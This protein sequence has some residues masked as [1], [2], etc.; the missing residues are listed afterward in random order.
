MLWCLYVV[1]PYVGG[2]GQKNSLVY[3]DVD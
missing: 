2:E 1:V 3:N